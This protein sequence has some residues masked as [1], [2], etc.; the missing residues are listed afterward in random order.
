MKISELLDPIEEDETAQ[1]E[2][3]DNEILKEVLE[4]DDDEET[5]KL[6]HLSQKILPEPRRLTSFVKC[7]LPARRIPGKSPSCL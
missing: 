6:R 1:P 7:L 3:T 5:V 2:L 4:A